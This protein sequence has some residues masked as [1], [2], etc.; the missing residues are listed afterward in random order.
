M[1]DGLFFCTPLKG[2]RGGYTPFVQTGV[3]KPDTGEGRLSRTLALHGRVIL[4]GGY[5]GLG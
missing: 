5:R 1:V 4:G 3:E 2:R